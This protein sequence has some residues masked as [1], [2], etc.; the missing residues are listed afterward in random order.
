MAQ[1]VI[2]QR[3]WTPEE[4]QAA[5]F[6]YYPRRK[7][8]TLAR[9]LPEAEAP[10]WIETAWAVL[11]ADAGDMICYRPEPGEAR[12]ALD[13][14]D[15]WPVRPDIFAQDYAAWDVPDLPDF[16]AVRQLLAAGCRAYY[17]RAGCWARRLAAPTAVLSLES[18]EPVVYPPGGWL[19]I[20]TAGEPWVQPDASFR[21]RYQVDD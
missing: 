2:R 20:G 10:L 14:Y 5:G 19:C 9:V 8:L 18:A 16:P 3:R 13:E 4:L 7:E 17:K 6:R 11:E 1:D 15:H 12:A 21:E